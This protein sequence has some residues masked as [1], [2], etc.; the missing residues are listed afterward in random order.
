MSGVTAA[1]LATYATIAGGVAA[2]GGAIY[3]ATKAG[4]KAP[5]APA[6]APT[7]PTTNDARKQA[8]ASADQD[9][10]KGVLANMLNPINSAGSTNSSL[11]QLLGQ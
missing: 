5:A 8:N 7:P 2:V 10:S 3:S 1:T 6:A 9:Q 11:K 4:P